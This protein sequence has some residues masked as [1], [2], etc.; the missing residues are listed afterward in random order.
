MK[1]YD[2]TLAFI[3]AIVALDLI[4]ETA[5]VVS[6]LLRSA[7]ILAAEPNSAYLRRVENGSLIAPVFAI[8]VSLIILAASRPIARFASALA[9]A[10]DAAGQF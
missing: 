8:V 10:T 5:T 4:R 9:A 7:Y 6:Y 1:V 3:R 2:I